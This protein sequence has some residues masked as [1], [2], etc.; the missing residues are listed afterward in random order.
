MYRADGQRFNAKRT[1]DELSEGK[2]APRSDHQ[3]DQALPRPTDDEVRQGSQQGGTQQR[4]DE[5]RRGQGHIP[6]HQQPAAPYCSM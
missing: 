4:K 3:Q 6:L 5:S 1:P 2:A